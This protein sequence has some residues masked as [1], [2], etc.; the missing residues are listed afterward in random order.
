MVSIFKRGHFIS[1]EFCARNSLWRLK[2]LRDICRSLRIRTTV[3]ER[4]DGS[5]NCLLSSVK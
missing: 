2:I 5:F 4:R 1:E 3:H